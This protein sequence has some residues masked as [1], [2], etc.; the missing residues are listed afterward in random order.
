MDYIGSKAKVNEWMFPIILAGSDPANEVFLDACAG[1]GSV[2]RYAAKSG[3]KKIISND[4]MEFPSHIILGSI[5]LPKSKLG[6]ATKLIDRI[7]KLPGVEGFFYRNYSQSSGRLFFTD[8]NAKKIDACRQFI[9]AIDDQAIKSYILYCLLEAFSGVSNCTGIQA[10]FLKQY[11]TRALKEIV[12]KP[13]AC[14]HIPRMVKTFN[15]DILSLLQ[16]SSAVRK[17]IKETLTYIDPPYNHRQY[18]PNYHLYETLVKYD[19][20]IIIGKVG[21]RDWKNESK[22]SFCSKKDCATF[23]KNVVD[24]T[25]ASRVFISYN[26]DGLLSKDEFMDIFRGYKIEL[27]TMP[28]KRYKADASNDRIYNETELLEY[29]FKITK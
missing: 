26:S 22:S 13:Q 9:E 23:T 1:S 17:K 4:I 10:A 28:Q 25:I 21:L 8:D 18:G 5:A 6:T 15:C 20:P 24:A 29:L 19:D 3:F 11:K 16:S 14:M 7:N 12:V 27:F 2:S